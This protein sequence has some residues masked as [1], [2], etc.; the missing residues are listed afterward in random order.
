MDRRRLV[1]NIQPAIIGGV[2][3][4]NLNDRVSGIKDEPPGRR[5]KWNLKA[6]DTLPPDALLDARFS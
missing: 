6:R 5:C 1:G 4:N 3:F 2:I